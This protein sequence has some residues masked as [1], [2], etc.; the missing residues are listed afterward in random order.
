MNSR[1]LRDALAMVVM[2]PFPSMENPATGLPVFGDA[3]DD[4]AGPRRLDADDDARGHVRVR[5]DADQ[6]AEEELEVFAELQTAVGVRQSERSLDVVRHRL[7]RRIGQIVERQDDDMI[8]NA[9][10]SVLAPIPVEVVASHVTTF[11]S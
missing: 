2:S 1:A 8:A 5:A 10:T 9:D 3:V 7:A 6:G 11:W 4:A